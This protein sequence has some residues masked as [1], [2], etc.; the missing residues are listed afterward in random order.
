MYDHLHDPR[1]IAFGFPSTLRDFSIMLT[2]H[3]FIDDHRDVGIA[4]VRTV[5]FWEGLACCL[6]KSYINNKQ[7]S[8]C[9]I[10]GTHAVVRGVRTLFNK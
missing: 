7:S 6:Y 9:D 3:M 4:C 1:P 2:A 8:G 10:N 5:F